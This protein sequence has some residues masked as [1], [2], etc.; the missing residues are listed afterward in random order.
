LEA[1]AFYEKVGRLAEEHGVL[2]NLV[3]IEGCDANIAGL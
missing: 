3:T 2:V 1:D